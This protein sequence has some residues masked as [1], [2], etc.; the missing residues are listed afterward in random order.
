MPDI[1]T[2]R[3]RPSADANREKKLHRFDGVA[4]LLLFLVALG[5]RLYLYRFNDVI[6][7]DGTGYVGTARKLM[8]GD[9]SGLGYYGFYPVLAWLLGLTGIDLETAAQLVSVIMG[10]LLVVPL[11]LLG[12]LLY[13]RTTALAACIVSIVWSSHLFVSCIVANQSTYTTLALTA[14][15]LVMRMFDRRLFSY[16][17]W[18]GIVMGLAFF[19]RPEAFLLF[20]VMPLAYVFENRREL[21]AVWRPIVAYGTVFAVILLMNTL[22]IHHFSGVWQLSAKTSSALGDSLSYYLKIRD[23]NLIPGGKSIGYLELITRYPG[24]ILTNP[25]QNLKTI[26]ETTLPVSLWLLAVI[27]FV[28]GGM[29]GQIVFK[30]LYLICTFAPLAVIILFYY[31]NGGYMEPYLPVLFLWCAEGG[32]SVE[33]FVMQR[34]L[35]PAGYC[36]EKLVRHTPGVLIASC[37]YAVVLL[38]PQIPEKRNDSTYTWLDDDCRFDHKRLGLMLK[39]YL[40][41]GKVMT[42][43][44]RLAYY[45]GHEMV[46]IPNTDIKG[47][48]RAAYAGG[49][50][51][52]V[53]YG[54]SNGADAQLDYLLEPLT[55]IPVSYFSI[56]PVTT[57]TQPGL[58]PY[59]VYSN[60]SSLGLIVYEIIR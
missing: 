57:V 55:R 39:Q 10:S 19:T 38:A 44:A 9:I 3:Y 18:A 14:V 15:Y 12:Q 5:I 6:S 21:R 49:A 34:V 46:A 11:Y 8:S 37:I 41:P 36:S 60:P 47:I 7:V 52:L 20:L 29:R 2:D 31:I 28:S 43:W 40:P 30:R 51:F 26:V 24:F 48:E 13:S 53:L 4:I 45:S 27:G 58:Y 42:R 54:G 56:T 50:R 16:G 32:R 17:C 23:V 22:L 1:I 33:R 25:I 35:V 59:L